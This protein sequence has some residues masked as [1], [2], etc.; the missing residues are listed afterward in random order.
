MVTGNV[1]AAQDPDTVAASSVIGSGNRIRQLAIRWGLPF[2]SLLYFVAVAVTCVLMF[3]ARD[4]FKLL[5]AFPLALNTGALLGAF[6]FIPRLR[7]EGFVLAWALTYLGVT[8]FFLKDTQR[9]LLATPDWR[10]ARNLL[11]VG[12]PIL[13]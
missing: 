10:I 9:H 11:R 12:A 7:L 13:L 4:Q 6:F 5:S 1:P 8:V 3:R 2:D